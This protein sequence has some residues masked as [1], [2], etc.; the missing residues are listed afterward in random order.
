[1]GLWSYLASKIISEPKVTETMVSGF[2]T[3]KFAVVSGSLAVVLFG[4]GY[5]FYGMGSVVK[6]VTDIVDDFHDSKGSQKSKGLNDIELEELDLTPEEIEESYQSEEEDVEG[7]VSFIDS[8][9]SAESEDTNESVS[10]SIELDQEVNELETATTPESK[11]VPSESIEPLE[12]S[13]Q[14]TETELE[15]LPTEDLPTEDLREE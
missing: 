1:M 9:E 2:S 4:V 10:K 8:G 11:T 14:E 3:A 7:K 6:P 13:Y 5:A 15:D 12:K